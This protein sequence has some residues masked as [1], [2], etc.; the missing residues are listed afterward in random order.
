MKMS[1]NRWQGRMPFRL[2]KEVREL[3]REKRRTG[4][5][6]PANNRL[7][8]YQFMMKLREGS[9][10]KAEGTYTEKL[11]QG[12][13][14]WCSRF[15]GIITFEYRLSRHR[16]ITVSGRGPIVYHD[17]VRGRGSKGMMMD[18]GV[19]SIDGLRPV[20]RVQTFAWNRIIGRERFLALSSGEDN[21]N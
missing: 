1:K 11:R 18:L 3:L 4:E 15:G 21:A 12:L 6:S 5:P 9:H 20:I 8:L 10:Q 19:I 7:E 16:I 13:W 14:E 17:W 2:C